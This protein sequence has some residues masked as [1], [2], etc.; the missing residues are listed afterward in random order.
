MVC[1]WPFISKHG[2][3]SHKVHCKLNHEMLHP[4]VFFH[5]PLTDNNTCTCLYL[6]LLSSLCIIDDVCSFSLFKYSIHSTLIGTHAAGVGGQNVP[7][8]SFS[9][10]ILTF[11][12]HICIGILAI[13]SRALSAKTLLSHDNLSS[14]TDIGVLAA[15]E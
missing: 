2:K 6:K 4:F 7:P 11:V 3:M 10:L 12:L 13:G 5:M 14:A 8:W 9:V 1:V 15:A